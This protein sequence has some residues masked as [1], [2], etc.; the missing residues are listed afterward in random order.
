ML[1]QDLA[2]EERAH[3][4]LVE[5]GVSPRWAKKFAEAGVASVDDL[6]EL[7]E[8]DLAALPG[9]GPKAVEEIIEGLAAN[10]LPG[11]K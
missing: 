10:G 1:E 11:L 8:S 9:I 3:A 5:I 7:T 4:S 6:A 2:N